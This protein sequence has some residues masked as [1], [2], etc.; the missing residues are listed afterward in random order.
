[1]FLQQRC[2]YIKRYV[3][4]YVFKANALIVSVINYMSMFIVFE[5]LYLIWITFRSFDRIEKYY[6]LYLLLLINENVQ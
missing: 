5:I 1:M 6:Y 4:H 3:K 2:K